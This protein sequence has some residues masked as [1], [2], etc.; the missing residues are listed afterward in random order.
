MAQVGAFVETVTQEDL[1]R[2]REPNAAPGYPPP[3]ARTAMSC[4]HV[5]FGEEWEHHRFAVRDLAVLET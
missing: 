3:A 1:D 4:L 5:I 2:T